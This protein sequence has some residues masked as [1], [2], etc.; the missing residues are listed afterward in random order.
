MEITTLLRRNNHTI[1]WQQQEVKDEIE[2]A[3]VLYKK[4]GKQKSCDAITHFLLQFDALHSLLLAYN[5]A[6]YKKEVDQYLC[7]CS[8]LEKEFDSSKQKELLRTV[9]DIGIDTLN[10]AFNVINQDCENPMD[11]TPDL[12][13]YIKKHRLN[14]AENCSDEEIFKKL[15]YYLN[16]TLINYNRINNLRLKVNS[17][18]LLANKSEATKTVI[19]VVQKIFELILGGKN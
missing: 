3:T 17:E 15:S 18:K 7:I 5:H 16:V 9:N 8:L 12:F 13:F 19:P 2:K 10:E 1:W 11:E 14:K 6:T 4:I